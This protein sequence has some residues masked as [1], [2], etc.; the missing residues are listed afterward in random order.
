MEYTSTARRVIERAKEEAV[1]LKHHYLGPYHTLLAISLIGGDA[2]MALE[3]Y[4]GR[5]IDVSELER[6]IRERA[7]P[8]PEE[9]PVE[10]DQLIRTP[11]YH[12]SLRTANVEASAMGHERVGTQHLLLGILS[13]IEGKASQLLTESGLNYS[14]LREIIREMGNPTED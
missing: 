14:E 11:M 10:Q 12:P 1:A 3:A 7:L 8:A 9:H 2:I 5:D 6:S 4:T 13:Q